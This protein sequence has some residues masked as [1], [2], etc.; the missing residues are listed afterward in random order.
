MLAHLISQK[1]FCQI[2]VLAALVLFSQIR[3]GPLFPLLKGERAQV[4]KN[5]TGAI[6]RVISQQMGELFL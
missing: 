1:Y 3:L 2:I 5:C 4:V 6:A